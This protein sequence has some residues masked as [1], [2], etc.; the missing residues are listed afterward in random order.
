MIHFEIGKRLVD[1]EHLLRAELILDEIGA[2]L[3]L[4]GARD[5]L[6]KLDEI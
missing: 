6:A 4:A 2:E 1:R 3:D 5:S